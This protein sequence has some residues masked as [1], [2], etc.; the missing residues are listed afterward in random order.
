M[1]FYCGY[2]STW[3]ASKHKFCPTCGRPKE[4][5]LCRRCKT[6][7][8]GNATHCPSCGGSDRL[9]ESAIRIW[10]PSRLL[11]IGTLAILISVAWTIAGPAALWL[12]GLAIQAERIVLETLAYLVAFWLLT[13]ALPRPHGQ[14]IRK[15][16]WWIVRVMARF[17]GNLVR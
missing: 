9:T 14:K 6:K 3:V 7:V 8:P 4:G 16:A 17:V 13:A 2:C 5:R 15:G 12:K 1:P 10:R 11:R